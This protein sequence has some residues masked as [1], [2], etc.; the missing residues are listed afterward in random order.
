MASRL[1]SPNTFK[2]DLPIQLDHPSVDLTRNHRL[3]SLSSSSI[4]DQTC[5]VHTHTRVY[6]FYIREMNDRCYTV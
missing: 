2:Q 4:V 6:F 1:N 5:V 3:A